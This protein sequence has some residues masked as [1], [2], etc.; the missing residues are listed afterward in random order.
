V[1]TGSLHRNHDFVLLW[2]GQTLSALGSQ[3]SLV[4]YPLLVLA[5]TGSPAKAG[6]VGFAKTVPFAAL[7]LPAGALADRV[8]RKRLMV[9]CDGVRALALTSIPIALSTGGVPYGLIVAVA[10]LDGSGYVV[11]MVA[12]RGALRQLVPQE[13]LGEAVARNE[14]RLFAAMLAGPPLG[15]LLFGFARV[16]PFLTDAV[17]YTASTLSLLLIKTGFQEPRAESPEPRGLAD[18]LRW[19]WRERFFRTCA[20]LFAA[21]NPLFTGLYLLIVVLAR[22]H[23]ASSALVGVMLGIAAAGGLLGAL[24]APTLQRRVSIRTV[25]IGESCVM[26]LVL[27]LLLLTREAVLLGL[28]VAAAE[29]LTPLTNSIVVSYRVALAPDRLQ[30]RVQ[31]AS[32]L[33]SFSGAW[34]GPL[35][36]GF[37]LQ[38]TGATTTILGACGWALLLAAAAI[39]TP[40]FRHP[41]SLTLAQAPESVGIPVPAP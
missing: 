20:L 1:A 16:V 18:G 19:L 29:L 35:A 3:I 40:A 8:N 33:L 14:S 36:V 2:S 13:Q 17:S 5:L 25:L 7:A 15:G 41:P 30:G 11:S 6:I 31:A 32:T 4:A 12:E 24:L 38:S 28:I 26:A 23:H 21:G 22:Q 39:L 10:F 37:M 9:V 34:L 27:P